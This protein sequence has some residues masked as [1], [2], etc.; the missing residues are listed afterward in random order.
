[1]KGDEHVERYTPHQICVKPFGRF[2]SMIESSK[3]EV[4]IRELRHIERV[5]CVIVCE[6]HCGTQ[7]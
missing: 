7:N 3:L 2:H 6:I 4:Q 5:L 1:M